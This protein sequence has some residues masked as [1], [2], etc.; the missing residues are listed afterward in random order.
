MMNDESDS[1]YTDN[2]SAGGSGVLTIEG[3]PLDL[4]GL[5]QLCDEFASLA[6]YNSH[7][8]A[9]LSQHLNTRKSEKG[10]VISPRSSSTTTQPISITR[11]TPKSGDGG[12]EDGHAEQEEQPLQLQSCP[13][14]TL[15]DSS[16]VSLL[17]S[18]AAVE[19][20]T[21][22]LQ[23][24]S[25]PHSTADATTLPTIAT[26]N[27]TNS[28]RTLQPHPQLTL[29]PSPMP[30]AKVAAVPVP[31]P[32]TVVFS[33]TPTPSA[34]LLTSKNVLL[35]ASSPTLS[36]TSSP[37]PGVVDFRR[38]VPSGSKS[39]SERR[40][41]I[42]SPIPSPTSSPLSHSPT[43]TP[44]ASPSG[45]KHSSLRKRKVPLTTRI[46]RQGNAKGSVIIRRDPLK[47]QAPRLEFELASN[48]GE[49]FMSEF[50]LHSKLGV[51]PRG[52]TY[53]AT[54]IDT[55]FALVMKGIQ[56][57]SKEN[58]DKGR[59]I[60]ELVKKI[61]GLRVFRHDALVD[62]YGAG[63]QDGALWITMQHCDGGS[64]W[65][66]LTLVKG[67][68]KEDDIAFIARKVVEGL[69][70]LDPVAHGN[71]KANNILF[72][73]SNQVKLSDYKLSR[74]LD[75][76][77]SF[78]TDQSLEYI[79][80]PPEGLGLK[81]TAEADLWA[82]GNVLL[83][84]ANGKP[85][86]K[87]EG[88]LK[89]DKP[90]RWSRNFQTFL[91][92][93]LAE[94]PKKRGTAEELRSHPFVARVDDRYNIGQELAKYTKRLHKRIDKTPFTPGGG[95]VMIRDQITVSKHSAVTSTKLKKQTVPDDNTAP[96]YLGRDA[97]TLLVQLPEGL[98]LEPPFE[99]VA[100]VGFTTGKQKNLQFGKNDV[101]TVLDINRDTGT[102]RGR[103]GNQE[104]LFP[105]ALVERK[106]E[107]VASEY[108]M[109][110]KR[111]ASCPDITFTSSNGSPIP[112]N[113]EKR[114]WRKS[115]RNAL[116]FKGSASRSSLERAGVGYGGSGRST[117]RDHK[118]LP[119]WPP[120]VPE[121]SASA[122]TIEALAGGSPDSPSG[123]TDS[124]IPPMRP[125]SRSKEAELQYKLETAAKEIE[126]LQAERKVAKAQAAA[127][128][129]QQ[130]AAAQEVVRLTRSA[131]AISTKK[132]DVIVKKE[133]LP[134]DSRPNNEEEPT[135][136]DVS[137]SLSAPEPSYH[138]AP[139]VS[140]DHKTESPLT[141][142]SSP[143][144]PTMTT[145][146][147]ATRKPGTKFADSSPDLPR[148][149]SSVTL[150]KSRSHGNS[151]TLRPVRPA[152]RWPPERPSQESSSTTTS[153]PTPS[154]PQTAR[155]ATAFPRA[156]T[157]RS[158]KSP[159]MGT[160]RQP[161]SVDLES[162]Q[163][164]TNGVPSK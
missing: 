31:V 131:D 39:L 156:Y 161:G 9:S 10:Q 135:E 66:Y 67:G 7:W 73:G 84:M 30:V 17:E 118:E 53:K 6:T 108:S 26:T 152:P 126:R 14:P 5:Q 47:P 64:V 60:A 147:F 81:P 74:L 143:T 138:S 133:A 129:Q 144:S 106:T 90:T 141:T 100:L 32:A 28:G 125:R 48:E 34:S 94:N 137:S 122:E 18:L 58:G 21:N 44:T 33:P 164:A 82:L 95:S 71:I 89:L 102:C 77:S 40:A 87:G 127:Q 24:L 15:H 22:Y 78:S 76:I 55:G 107:E 20:K 117:P 91:A 70:Y 142:S 113:K 68:M 134:S 69:A 124:G 45:S 54:H 98:T 8:F 150:H 61:D 46:S 62:Y 3:D 154:R 29:I 63:V 140:T 99:V 146:A 49:D 157:L 105:A 160:P 35:P 86:P 130:P 158:A 120:S 59:S 103:L 13:V 96:S 153:E 123:A 25:T 85:K 104:G 163:P 116:S 92:R 119:S 11:R 41:S 52:K 149:A 56:V 145:K 159:S 16:S 132:K 2:G 155:V 23:T 72:R 51:G 57:T 43:H 83:H 79:P 37:P 50:T 12:D 115:I 128:Q 1:D 27:T 19:E 136:L 109:I 114:E 93:C 97:A 148:S 65:D 75:P 80:P 139:V 111:A 88:I 4:A 151:A 121:A 112:S 162:S 38:P 36:P 42:H 110:E 101:I